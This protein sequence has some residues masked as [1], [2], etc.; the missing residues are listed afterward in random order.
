[1]EISQL[2]AGMHD[3]S[4]RLPPFQR[5]YAWSRQRALELIESLYQRYPTGIITL[6]RQRPALG[7]PQY[8]IVDGQQRL[9]SIYAAALGQA[10]PLYSDAT[11]PPPTDLHFDPLRD[12]FGYSKPGELERRPGWLPVTAV[13]TDDRA[14]LAAWRQRSAPSKDFAAQQDE[15]LLRLSRLHSIR[16]RALPVQEID[17]ELDS[18]AVLEIFRRINTSRRP[19]TRNDIAMAWI[20]AR[21]PD[22][23]TEFR[24][25]IRQRRKGILERVIT[26]DTIIRTMTAI[27]TG[28]LRP[29]GLALAD[30]SPGQLAR[31]FAQAE[32]AFAAIADAITAELG[33]SDPRTL[34]TAPLSVLARR[35]S[36]QDG[37]FRDPTD[38]R[39]GMIYLLR[40]VAGGPY[41]SG[42]ASALDADLRALD[43]SDPPWAALQAR[44]EAR[45]GQTFAE[46][47]QFRF[48]L[49]HR[50]SYYIVWHALLKGPGTRDWLTRLPPDDPRRQ[51]PPPEI[52]PTL[53]P[54]DDTPGTALAAPEAVA[55]TAAETAQA[56]AASAQNR[57]ADAQDAAEATAASVADVAAVATAV[58]D[59]AAAQAIAEAAEAAATATAAP[60]PN[61]SQR[62]AYQALEQALRLAVK[63]ELNHGNAPTLATMLQE[64]LTYPENCWQG[65]APTSNST[66]ETIINL[67]P[68]P[69]NH[70]YPEERELI[71]ICQEEKDQSRKFIIYCT[72]TNTRSTVQRTQA[73]LQQH[74]ITTA[75]M[76]AA[77]VKPEKRMQWFQDQARHHDGII[78]NP[79][80]VETGIDL[81]DYPTIIWQETEYSMYTTDQA[82]AHSNRI[83]QTQPIRIHYLAYAGTMQEQA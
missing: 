10:P 21:W 80:A 65:A 38:R 76:D 23:L 5:G 45:L 53:V 67:P 15:C 69:A 9:A 72:H 46:P 75:Y 55:E 82:S 27:H 17:P 14:A 40:A 22:A 68:L 81:L 79:K 34:T 11:A 43:A 7:G 1:M 25:L 64:L 83:S 56:A 20:A 62:S 70:T 6:W 2:I 54:L 78:V 47:E 33:L 57:A 42:Y 41:R 63:Q 74:H 48:G 24:R 4:I 8:L 51:L 19:L 59:A 29:H 39:Q 44:R 71:R 49:Y 12:I 35:L 26:Q 13:L 77:R 31:A 18:A 28:R 66:G 3:G 36:R 30:P 52:I 58:A 16:D 37:A 32:Q 50:S 73:I 61:Y 60:T